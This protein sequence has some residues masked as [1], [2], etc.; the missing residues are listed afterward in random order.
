M[1]QQ[2]VLIAGYSGRA[3]AASARRAGYLPLVADAFADTDT[4]T[5]AHA[6]EHLPGSL[7]HGFRFETLSAALDRLTA[8]SECPSI[9]LV[10]AAG[11]EDD[12]DLVAALASRYTL[13]GCNAD[14]IRAAK[15]PDHLF[16]IATEL[17][18]A[19]P[20]T[21]R[22]PPADATGWLSKRIGGSGGTHI[23][24][25]RKRVTAHSD[26]YLQR[27]VAGEPLSLLGVVG[28]GAAFAFTRSWVDPAPRRP[29]RFGGLFGSVDID[30]DLEARLIGIGVDLARELGLKGLVSF[31]FIVAEANPMLIEVNPRP[32]ASLDV[33]DD[34]QGSLFAAHVA[35]CQGE[36][37]VPIL[38]RDWRPL[39][40]GLAY[41]YADR[42]PLTVPALD[43]PAWTTDRPQVA[44][45]IPR[46]APVMTVHAE[47]AD[48]AEARTRLTE[49][50]GQINSLLYGHEKKAKETSR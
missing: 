30:A 1:S 49:R 28:R 20:D 37:P 29:H 41:L 19:F 7:S 25:C 8:K 12:P 33:L 42:G 3:L 9:G 50:L 36:D 26:R 6:H 48:Q 35:A 15:D 18:I 14:T 5:I 45:T 32:G 22:A 44:A 39:R 21:R 46:H 4:A 38:A 47:A 2:A 11:F 23:A 10:L 13:V 40:R 34:D 43:W 27:E 31:D 16:A 24:R 17:G